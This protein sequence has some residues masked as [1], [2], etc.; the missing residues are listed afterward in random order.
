MEL[1]SALSGRKAVLQR[2]SSISNAIQAGLDGLA[3]IG[4]AWLLVEYHVGV[5][6]AEYLVML[7][8]L[9]GILAVAYDHHALYRS[10]RSFTGKA[11]AL[12]RAWTIGFAVLL[13][14]AFVTKQSAYF[15][16]LVVGELYVLG[17]LAQLLLHLAFQSVQLKLRQHAFQPENA[18]IVGQGSLAS[19][20][21]QKVSCNPWLGQRVIGSVTLDG[22]DPAAQLPSGTCDTKPLGSVRDLPRLI[23]SRA[24]RTVY[25]VTSLDASKD[26]EG[27]YA[28]LVDKHVA[29]HWI[30]D[31]FSLRLVNHNVK[32][33][34]GIPLLTLSE[35][36]LIGTRMLWKSIEDFTLSAV[37]LL[38][39]SPLLALIALAIKLES[40]GPVFFRQDRA[41]WNGKTFR[42]WKFRSM[43]VQPVEDDV[44]RQAERDDPRVTRVGCFL[45]RTS[46]DE[47]PQL[48]NVLTGSMSLVGP[49]PH[50]IQHDEEYSRRIADY[51]ARHK[52]K[53]GIT[54]LAQ[55]RGFRGETRELDRMVQRIESD[56]EYI[57]NWSIWLDLLILFRTFTA[58]TG[59]YAY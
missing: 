28:L 59:K 31:I 10:N 32:E 20:L 43:H 51:F 53:P 5:F 15:S 27:I 9:M 24:V 58:L 8:L 25:I 29:V 42:I 39:I 7:L 19:Y 36:P 14:I 35:T 45:R 11:L 2:R 34:A 13:L 38:A 47:L 1:T 55:V 22:A 52:I 57:N 26:I 37:I 30:P 44:I 33:I 56:I 6:T 18:V 16:R 21:S 49:R 17:L 4:L 46:L 50:A 41:G 54:G 12:F 23:D 48:F 3:V 40:P